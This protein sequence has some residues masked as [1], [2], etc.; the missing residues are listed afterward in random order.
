VTDFLTSLGSDDPPSLEGLYSKAL[1][2]PEGLLGFYHEL[3]NFQEPWAM[4]QDW[5]SVE[6]PT[7]FQPGEF[8]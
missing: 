4:E 5:P 2:L 1:T 6:N 8:Q 7:N 3:R